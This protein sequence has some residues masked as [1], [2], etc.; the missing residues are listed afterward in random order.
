MKKYGIFYA[1]STGRT[2][3]AAEAIAAAL[4]IPAS[5]IHNVADTAPSELGS[6]DV[7]ILG[8][9]TYAAGDMQPHM[10]DFIDGAQALDLS[11]HKLAF[12]GTG[13]DTMSRTFCS[14]VGDMAKALSHTGAVQIGE[15]DARGYVF[16]DS[17]AEIA[18][19]VYAG[20]LLDDIN[21]P[22][23][24]PGRIEAWA[25]KLRAE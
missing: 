4:D 24:T 6:Y 13:D 22:D 14:A 11:G 21:H 9:P 10:E 23:L 3:K 15:F 16:D 1:S 2:A 12:F 8:S 18:P 19:G 17:E 20:L 25:A 7:A 5:D